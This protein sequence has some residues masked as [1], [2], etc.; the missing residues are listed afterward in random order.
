MHALNFLLVLLFF[1][2]Y[3]I[4]P[5]S[6]MYVNDMK[7]GMCC[8]DKEP[9]V[10]KETAATALVEGHNLLGLLFYYFCKQA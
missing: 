9:E 2:Y 4:M 3:D 5:V 1:F 7:M 10:V 6:D 8:C